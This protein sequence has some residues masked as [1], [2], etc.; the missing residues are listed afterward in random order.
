MNFSE[1]QKKMIALGFTYKKCGTC[2]NRNDKFNKGKK[3]VR[4]PSRYNLRNASVLENNRL[5]AQRF[6]NYEELLDYL[7]D[8]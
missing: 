6:D 7:N 3:E 5:I 8:Y 2:S 4:I 1:F